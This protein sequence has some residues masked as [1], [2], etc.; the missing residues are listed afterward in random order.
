MM[1]GLRLKIHDL[2]NQD[3]SQLTNTPISP[4]GNCPIIHTNTP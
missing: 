4:H 1:R 3:V 2:S